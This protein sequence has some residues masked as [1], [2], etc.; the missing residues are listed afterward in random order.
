MNASLGPR[1]AG[2]QGRSVGLE[3]GVVARR[4]EQNGQRSRSLAVSDNGL[5]TTPKIVQPLGI[6]VG[7]AGRHVNQLPRHF[8]GRRVAQAIRLD[9]FLDHAAERRKKHRQPPENPAGTEGN[10]IAVILGRTRPGI[11][12]CELVMSG[13]NNQN[14]NF[15]AVVGELLMH[16]LEVDPGLGEDIE[17]NLAIGNSLGQLPCHDV[18]GREPFFK[19][20]AECGRASDH[21]D[22]DLVIVRAARSRG[23]HRQR[24]CR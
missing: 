11:A 23:Q 21:R 17:P 9:P 15:L 24:G 14:V 19:R 8:R 22:V 12:V 6:L 7:R 20:Q 18:T 13:E 1:R 4:D 10:L 16:P 3:S 5:E 2:R